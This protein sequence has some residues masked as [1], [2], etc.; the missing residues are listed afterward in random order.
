MDDINAG[1]LG[2]RRHQIVRKTDCHGLALGVVAHLLEEGRPHPLGEGA[3]GLSGDDQGIDDAATVF[4]DDIALD[5]NC[6]RFGINL[7]QGHMRS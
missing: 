1:H 6:V 2:C 3:P 4:R 7:H 5:M